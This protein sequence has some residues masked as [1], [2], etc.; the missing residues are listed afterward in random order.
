[1]YGRWIALALVLGSWGCESGEDDTGAG[2]AGGMSVDGGSGGMGG[3]GG[4]SM[5]MTLPDGSVDMA[6]APDMGMAIGDMAVDMATGD[7][8]AGDMGAGDMATGD[9]GG[10]TVDCPTV[11]TRFEMEC[12]QAFTVRGD[13]DDCDNLVEGLMGVEHRETFV[14]SA[15]VCAQGASTGDCRA[16]Y[17]CV[18]DNDGLNAYGDSWTVSLQGELNGEAINIEVADAWG[19]VGTKGSTGGPSDLEVIFEHQGTFWVMVFDDLAVEAEN[20]PLDV[21][22]FPIKLRN[23][24]N[25]LVF[26]TGEIQINSFDLNGEVAIRAGA[27]LEMDMGSLSIQVNGSFL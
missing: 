21:A 3:A 7:M 18:S 24:Q 20:A 1:M 27:D 2:G 12:A 19:T 10:L 15:A 4:V 5:D 17:A 23:A 13:C 8:G 16:L 22:E 9:M 6:H 14:R 11:C 25:R 26:A